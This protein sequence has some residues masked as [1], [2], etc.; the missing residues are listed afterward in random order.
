[1]DLV[2][3][4][5][6][7]HI[8]MTPDLSPAQLADAPAPEPPAE[9]PAPAAAQEH[10][11]RYQKWGRLRQLDAE[12]IQQKFVSDLAS[13]G[14]D[15][16]SGKVNL[17]PVE[18]WHRQQGQGDKRLGDLVIIEMPNPND[19]DSPYWAFGEECEPMLCSETPADV[20]L[21]LAELLDLRNLQPKTQ[22][23]DKCEKQKLH[24]RPGEQFY[25][26]LSQKSVPG[27][28][29]PPAPAQPTAQAAPEEAPEQDAEGG[30]AKRAEPAAPAESP[31]PAEPNG[32]DPAPKKDVGGQ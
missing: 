23:V 31:R 15:Q 12:E 9:A 7:D 18:V 25:L 3:D 10:G 26:V 2:D 19:K 21:T 6:A 22:F 27:D 28:W 1:M 14:T 17:I 32:S 30:G 4:A 8:V 29:R 5:Q 16:V 20:N 11:G 13:V 24:V